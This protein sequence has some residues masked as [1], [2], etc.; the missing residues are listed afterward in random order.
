MKSIVT[1]N[2][3]K[4]AEV[5]VPRK[6][7]WEGPNNSNCRI[8]MYVPNICPTEC[9]TEAY[10]RGSTNNIGK[11]CIRKRKGKETDYVGNA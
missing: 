5:I 9:E 1:T 10:L 7:T 11:K 8:G 6:K 3:E 4:S 2:Y